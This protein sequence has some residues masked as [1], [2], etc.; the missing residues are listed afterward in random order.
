M[1]T[2]Q[3]KEPLIFSFYPAILNSILVVVWP[4]YQVAIKKNT[5]LYQSVKDIKEKYANQR[6]KK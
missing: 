4:I 5:I 6:L 1:M 2:L 3:H